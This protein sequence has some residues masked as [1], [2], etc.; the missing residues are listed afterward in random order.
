MSIAC[1][2][3]Q[4]YEKLPLLPCFG[5]L[6]PSQRWCRLLEDIHAY[7][8]TESETHT[9]PNLILAILFGPKFRQVVG[10]P[11][12]IVEI[13][14]VSFRKRTMKLNTPVNSMTVK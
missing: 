12:K 5:L 10:T 13:H 6:W 11:T 7:T 3:Y 1:I 8:L 2:T 14:A 4:N 9:P